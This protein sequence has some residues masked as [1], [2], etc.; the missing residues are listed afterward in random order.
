MA[1]LGGCELHS[2]LC[3]ATVLHAC[4]VP[5]KVLPCLNVCSHMSIGYGAHYLASIEGH[6]GRAVLYSPAVRAGPLHDVVRS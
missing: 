4:R 1:F 5:A 2:L 6:H 3:A